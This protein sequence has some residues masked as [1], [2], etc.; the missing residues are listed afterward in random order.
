VINILCAV[1]GDAEIKEAMDFIRSL[2]QTRQG[3]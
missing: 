2:D 1:V 3:R